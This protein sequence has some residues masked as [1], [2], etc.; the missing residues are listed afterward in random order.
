MR[1]I[2]LI[3][4]FVFAAVLLLLAALHVY[5]ALGGQWGISAT[6]PT[7]EG[8]RTINPGRGATFAVAFLLV[9]GA[10]IACGQVH[11]F[12]TGRFS[13]LF[14]VGSWCLCGVFLLRAMGDFRTFG[15]F[16]TVRGTAFADWDTKL[17]SPLCFV[18]AV[19]AGMVSLGLD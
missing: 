18:L 2:R 9:M 14:R 1:S 5:W 4:A 6:I 16:K 10:A 12:A 11:L 3:C 7:V 19:L 15:V 13:V 17:Y 8:R